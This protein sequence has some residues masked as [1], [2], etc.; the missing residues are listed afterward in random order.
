MH[1]ERMLN[2]YPEIIKEIYEIQAIIDGEYPEFE[3]TD[4]AMRGIANNA[5]L[6]TMDEARICQWEKLLKINPLPNSTAEDRRDNI[7][8]RIRGTGKLNT[9]AINNIVNAFTNGQAVSRIENS[10][11]Y[12]GILPPLNNKQFKFANV[13]KELANRV[14]AHLGL[15]VLRVYGSWQDIKNDFAEWN[16]VKTDFA[17]WEDVY[18]YIHRE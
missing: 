18:I 3:L 16:E 2:Y 5:Y 6:P 1:R 11:L 10:V 9:E 14:P 7:I 4:E 13:E 8:A 15:S 17:T 12:V